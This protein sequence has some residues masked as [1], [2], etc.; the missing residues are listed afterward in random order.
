MFLVGQGGC[1]SSSQIQNQP[2]CWLLSVLS[3]LTRLNTFDVIKLGVH[4]MQQT[5]RKAE[6]GDYK[7]AVNDM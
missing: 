5:S 7:H 1:Q 3:V 6:P 2:Q 4:D